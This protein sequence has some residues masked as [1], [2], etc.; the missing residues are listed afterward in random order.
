MENILTNTEDDHRKCI[1]TETEVKHQIKEQKQTWE[2]L[3]HNMKENY[4]DNEI[5]LWHS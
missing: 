2:D 4:L 5:I 3:G 1:N